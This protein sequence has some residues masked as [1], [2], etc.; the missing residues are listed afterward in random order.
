MDMFDMTK[1]KTYIHGPLLFGAQGK[2]NKKKNMKM[3]MINR[4]DNKCD[5]IED[6]EEQ[7]VMNESNIYS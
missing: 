5:E 6:S 7:C 3:L 4:K 2:N 1:N